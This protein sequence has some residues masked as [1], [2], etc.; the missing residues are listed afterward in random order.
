MAGTSPS[1]L[2]WIC[3]SCSGL[4]TMGVATGTLTW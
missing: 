3:L 1:A 2:Y 4:A